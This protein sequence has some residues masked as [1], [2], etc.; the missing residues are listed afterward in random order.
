MLSEI[1]MSIDIAAR[2][3]IR[4]VVQRKYPNE[5]C[6]FLWGLDGMITH[7]GETANI[8]AF[9]ISEHFEISS[10]AFVEAERFA[11]THALT[12][13]GIFHSHP[14]SVGVPSDEDHQSAL[15]NFLY[16]IVSVADHLV[17]EERL[18]ILDDCGYFKELCLKSARTESL[19]Q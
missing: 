19:N 10:S 5:C 9:D 16:L 13:M 2:D 12:L 1:Y 11:E 7:A 17:V 6:G 4:S 14:D 15:P 8:S 18:W 3:S